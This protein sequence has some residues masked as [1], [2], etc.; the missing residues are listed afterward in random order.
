M[1]GALVIFALLPILSYETDGYTR[2]NS[3]SFYTNPLCIIIAMGAGTLGSIIISSIINGTI[4]L[5]DLLHGPIAGAI[6]VGASSLYISYPIYIIVSGLIGGI[7][8]AFIQ[9]AFEKNTIYK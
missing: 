6:A 5:R 1:I 3:H 9:N 2:Y 8:Q 4:I 7:V